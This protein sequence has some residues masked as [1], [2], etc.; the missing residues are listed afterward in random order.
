MF[1]V[2]S[3]WRSVQ[4]V[5]TFSRMTQDTDDT[6][7][8]SGPVAT[9]GI[10]MPTCGLLALSDDQRPVPTRACSSPLTQ[11]AWITAKRRHRTTPAAANLVNQSI[12]PPSP[13]QMENRFTILE[14]LESPTSPAAVPCDSLPREIPHGS[15][16]RGQRGR[17]LL[18]G[19]RQTRRATATNTMPPERNP[20]APPRRTSPPQ[21][22]PG[23]TMLIIGDSIVRDVRLK[24]AKTFCF[25]GAT[26]TDIAE[27]IPN[28]IERHPTATKV[29]IHVGT[30]DTK[31]QQS[32]LLKRDFVSFLNSLENFHDRRFFISGPIPTLGRSVGWFSR[33]LSLHTWLQPQVSAHGLFYVD[34]FNLFWDRPQYFKQDG[35]HPNFLGSRMLT[36]NIVHS[37]SVSGD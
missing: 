6:L 34:N 32:E 1:I 30:N 7:P 3:K 18:P 4:T 24:S 21:R 27:K 28:L 22:P 8:W 19:P 14:E 13:V 31:R 26:V 16:S 25:P 12:G 23:P 20:H 29:V 36:E 5:Y 11:E 37:I 9:A 15:T 17:G 10:A 2:V 35:L 33:L